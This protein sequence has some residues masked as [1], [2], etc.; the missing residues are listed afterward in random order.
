MHPLY[1]GDYAAYDASCGFDD[2]GVNNF[3]DF[4]YSDHFSTGFR[5]APHTASLFDKCFVFWYAPDKGRRHT[6]FQAVG[7]FKSLVRGL[8]VGFNGKDAVNTVLEVGADGGNG[9][10]ENLRMPASLVNEQGCAYERHLRGSV[11]G[12]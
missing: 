6:A 2:R 5:T 11:L 10:I 9:V 12:L 1:T 3:Y 4:C 8:T 7:A